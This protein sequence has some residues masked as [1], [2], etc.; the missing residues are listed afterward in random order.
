MKANFDTLITED[1]PVIVDFH[2]LWCGPCK[3]Q[4]PIL[5]QLAA[6]QGDN[7]KI[8]KIDVDQNPAIA[9]RYQIRSVPTLMIFKNG[10]I[11][12]KQP[13]VHSKQQLDSLIQQYK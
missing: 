3:M 8:I 9:D 10:E 11:K 2:A 1:R 4:A 6:E 13:G 7:V 5:Q 12:H